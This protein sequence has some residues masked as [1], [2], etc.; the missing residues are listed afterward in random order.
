MKCNERQ[1]SFKTYTYTGTFDLRIYWTGLREQKNY[2]YHFC[3]C[4][5]ESKTEEVKE[6]HRK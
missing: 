4:L 3:V 5:N 1:R 2:A 6:R